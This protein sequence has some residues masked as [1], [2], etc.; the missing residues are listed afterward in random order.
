[1]LSAPRCFRL[2]RH[3]HKKH[4]LLCFRFL[5]FVQIKTRFI[6]YSIIV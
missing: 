2:L 5:E 3:M 6:A 1:M 4:I